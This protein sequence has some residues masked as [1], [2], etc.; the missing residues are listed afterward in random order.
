MVE[1]AIILCD[2]DILKIKHFQFNYNNTNYIHKLKNPYK[3]FNLAE[4][5]RE[6]ISKAL[7]QTNNNK[8][9]AAILLGIDRKRLLRK[10]SLYSIH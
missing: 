4:N 5:E 8:S 9:Q 7:Q 10:I 1:R 2:D 6:L 3:N